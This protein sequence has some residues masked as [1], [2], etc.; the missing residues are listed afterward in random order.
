VPLGC[1]PLGKPRAIPVYVLHGARPGPVMALTAAVHGDELN[2]VSI[3]HHLAFGDD[4]IADTNDDHIDVSKL[5][6]TLLCVPVVNV[7]GMI[8]QTRGTPD[9]RDLNRLFPGKATGNQAQRIAHA[10]FEQIVR[11]A[12]YLI[13]LH[14]APPTRMNVPHVRSNFDRPECKA[15]ARAFGT[16]IVL[17]AVGTAGTLRRE[18]AEAGV[19]TVL[20]ESGTSHRFEIGTIQV[21]VRGILNVM[22]HIGMIDRKPIPPAWRLLVRRSRWVRTAEGGLLHT[23]IEGGALVRAGDVIAHVTDPVGSRVASIESPVTG[24][25]LGLTTT[26]LVRAGDP[27]ANIVIVTGKRLERAIARGEA[28]KDKP[29]TIEE[30]EVA[31]KEGHTLDE[32]GD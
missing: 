18:A 9:G 6:G 16:E 25:V 23:V 30:A 14:T 5:A 28:R 20:L 27:I 31:D 2:G 8:L 26:P 29:G 32:V 13:D 12:D 15:L 24:L 19:A 1:D 11:R 3:I 22:A 7:E 4:H 10:L 17:H 21:G